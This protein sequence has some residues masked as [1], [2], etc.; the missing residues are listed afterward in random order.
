MDHPARLRVIPFGIASVT[1]ALVCPPLEQLSRRYG[2]MDVPNER[3]S[4]TVVTPRTGG[5]ACAV[6]ILAADASTRGWSRG[7]RAARAATFALAGLGLADDKVGLRPL[8]RLV[9]QIAVGVAYGAVTAG[10]R[11][12]LVG[13]SVLPAT[14]NA[15]NFM[16]GI[17][18]I[19]AST[20]V[21]WALNHGFQLPSSPVRRAGGASPA[22][23]AGAALGFLPFN[24][25]SAR[26]FLGDSGSYL[27]GAAMGATLIADLTEPD[28]PGAARVAAAHAPL[29]VYFADTGFTIVWRAMRGASLTEAHREHIYQRLQAS[30]P[31]PHWVV[32][33]FIAGLNAVLAGL[34]HAF[35]RSSYLRSDGEPQ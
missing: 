35:S 25:P 12:A 23:I 13:G 3:S 29:L 15:T 4:H 17:N 21:T 19:T 22:P 9:A 7:G 27:F 26:L 16:D 14:V 5:I 34:M 28:S 32:S 11:G 30:G 10:L 20:V 8:P 18:G 31:Y 2:V 24:A 6:G 1:T 33:A